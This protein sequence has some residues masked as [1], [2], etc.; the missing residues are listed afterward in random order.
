MHAGPEETI[1]TETKMPGAVPL[2][3]A[4][5][6]IA[7]RFGKPLVEL[8]ALG[9]G[10]AHAF[11]DFRRTVLRRGDV[12]GKDIRRCPIVLAVEVQEPGKKVLVTDFPLLDKEASG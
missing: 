12:V 6:P 1:Q 11:L 4:E 10:D 5:G 2:E 8:C 9:S 3:N 7:N